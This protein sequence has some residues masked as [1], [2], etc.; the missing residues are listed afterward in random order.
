MADPRRYFNYIGFL[1]FSC[2]S[3]GN[4]LSS[5]SDSGVARRKFTPEFFSDR[6]L[7]FLDAE[8]SRWQLSASIR[9]Y[10]WVR[11]LGVNSSHPFH[12]GTYGGDSS[13]CLLENFELLTPLAYDLWLTCNY[14]N[15]VSIDW[16]TEIRIT[17]GVF[18]QNEYSAD[19]K[20]A[21]S[22]LFRH[23]VEKY[24]QFGFWVIFLSIDNIASGGHLFVAWHGVTVVNLSK[25]MF[26]FIS[27]IQADIEFK[28]RKKIITINWILWKRNIIV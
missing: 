23:S 10:L 16:E 25:C 5:F 9:S 1:A 19:L 14:C 15:S 28:I 12:S 6:L 26:T 13:V 7:I 27:K 20:I 24:L 21:L 17:R 3:F 8:N 11:E 2:Y 18:G 4:D 22:I